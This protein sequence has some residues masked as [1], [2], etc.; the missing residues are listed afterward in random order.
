MEAVQKY[1]TISARRLW[2]MARERGYS[3]RSDHFR[4][5]VASIRPARQAQAYLRLA[6]LPG[7][8]AQVD[9]GHFG[10]LTV[11]RAQRKLN[12]FVMTLSYSRRGFLYFFFDQRLPSFLQ[13]HVG[14]FEAFGGVPRVILYDNLKAVVTQRMGDAILFQ[15][16]LLEFSAHYKYEPR[17]VGVCRG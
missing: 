13:G 11:G 16:D 7:E 4:Q 1:P 10:T 15:P 14:A 6:T 5:I 12:A 2:E 8:Q 9:W 17:P 3:G